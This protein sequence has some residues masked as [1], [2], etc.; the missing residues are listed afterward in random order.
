MLKD[1][2]KKM[3]SNICQNMVKG[4]LTVVVLGASV[5]PGF[6]MDKPPYN[7][8]NDQPN[9]GQTYYPNS[10]QSQP[11]QSGNMN[12]TS[13][14]IGAVPPPNSGTVPPPPPADSWPTI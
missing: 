13:S 1:L 6:A 12:A 8:N 9:M 11:Q 2:R 3:L 4:A 7:P 14:N 10:N 5:N